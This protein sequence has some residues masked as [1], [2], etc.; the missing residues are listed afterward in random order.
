MF[1]IPYYPV[2]VSKLIRW[3]TPS[4][5]WSLPNDA[6][7]V[8][9]TF[10]DGPIPEVTPWVL[11]VLQY[12]DV[13]ATFFCIGNNVASYPDVYKRILAE[14]HTIGN[15]T[16]DHLNGWNTEP[17]LYYQNIEKA[18]EL[19]DSK[20]FRPPYGRIKTKQINHL[21]EHYQIIMWDILSGDFDQKKSPEQCI[22]NVLRNTTS[23][24]IIVMHD[25]LKAEQNIKGSLE[26]IIQRILEKGY[27][28]SS[29]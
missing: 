15:H 26:K 14:G 17:N 2:K 7:K 1:S 9:L 13:K 16:Y 6:N 11:D 22:D 18:A 29:L 21:K 27:K 20:L 3:F 4:L 10:D 8:Y 24:S 28:F 19:I 12:Y 5:T 25:S 23:G